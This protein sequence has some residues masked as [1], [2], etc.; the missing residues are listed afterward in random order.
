M[1]SEDNLTTKTT[2]CFNI[3]LE[4]C[5]FLGQGRNGRVYLIPNGKTLK[6]FFKEK[7]CKHEYEILKS[8]DGN[9]HFPKVYEYKDNCIIREY[10]D[11]IPIKKYIQTYELNK[12]LVISII[13]LIEDFK[14]LG[15]TRLDIRCEHIF[16]QQDK[17]IKIIDPRSTYTKVVPYPYSILSCLNRLGVLDAFFNTLKEINHDLFENWTARYI[18]DKDNNISYYR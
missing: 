1:N 11:G 17:S 2:N 4:R 14:K 15:F 10:V 18:Y 6:I 7:N 9:K 8:A 16:I 5:I 13:N 3:D 12:S